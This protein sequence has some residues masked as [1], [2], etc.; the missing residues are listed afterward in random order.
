MVVAVAHTN[1]FMLNLNHLDF[2]RQILSNFSSFLF[3]RCRK[4]L[5]EKEWWLKGL[6]GKMGFCE[7]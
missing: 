7:E 4:A 1:I 3:I 5:V 2:K 6:C